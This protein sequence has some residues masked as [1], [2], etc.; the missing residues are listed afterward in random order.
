VIGVAFVLR[1]VGDTATTAGARWV[2]WL[3]PIGWG[4]QI[5]PYAGDR[6]WVALIGIAFAAL[7][8]AGAI[9][10]ATERDLGAGL[11]PDRP[12]PRTARP[13]LRGPLA[14]AWR[15]QRGTLFAWLGGF[16]VL[17]A[18]VGNVA[19]SVGDLLDSDQ[20]RDLIVK[21]GGDKALTDS[22]LAAELGLLGTIGTAYGVQ[23]A[24]RMRSE[25]SGQ[26]AEPLLATATSRIAWAGSHVLMALLGCTAMMLVAGLSAGVAYGASI[27]DMGR[28]APVLA[29]ALVQLPAM[30]LVV[31]IVVALFGVVPR[32]AV[33]GWAVL[34]AFLL[35]GELGPVLR[36]SQW[37][38]D[39]SPW[40]HLPKLPGSDVQ[41][42][43]LVV[44]V[45]VAAVLTAGGLAAFRRRD[46]AA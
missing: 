31:G 45:V 34:V 7:V 1:A 36:L 12:G 4:Q 38:M 27:G 25:E 43:P 40:A 46:L 21:L 9:A 29:A 26:R 14:L 19:S 22:F 23:A 20:A 39:L 32:I 37:V 15:L 30:W 11:L 42:L 6:L 33:A 18:V 28:V 16:L 5:R 41:A 24:L 8:T 44:L 3:S 10:L 17:G 2:R 13:S 35:L